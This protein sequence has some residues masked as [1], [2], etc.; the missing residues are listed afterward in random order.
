M[1]FHT[2]PLPAHPGESRDPVCAADA[3]MT[4]AMSRAHRIRKIWKRCARRRELSR[5]VPAFAG[6]SGAGMLRFELRGVS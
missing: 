4:A 6:M 2:T 1:G 3:A 5:W